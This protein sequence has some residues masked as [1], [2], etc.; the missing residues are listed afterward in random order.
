MASGSTK[1]LSE[2]LMPRW[3][4]NRYQRSNRVKQKKKANVL[5]SAFQIYLPFRS[6]ENIQS[7]QNFRSVDNED[8]E[9]DPSINQILEEDD[10]STDLSTTIKE[11]KKP[12]GGADAEGGGGGE[13][14]AEGAGA[15]G[16]SDVKSRS[17]SGGR[18]GNRFKRNIKNTGSLIVRK[19]RSSGR[20]GDADKKDEMH[21][22]RDSED[23]KAE[24]KRDKETAA[25]VNVIYKQKPNTKQQEQEQQQQE[26]EQ[27]KQQQN[28]VMLRTTTL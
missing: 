23:M 24:E 1:K 25:C 28:V 20:S 8:Q 18:G 3:S 12:N 7:H 6:R 17:D 21:T 19:F 4:L 16:I 10:D 9:E 11:L 13:R 15:G 27:E 14:E 2:Q 5:R 22:S 26:L